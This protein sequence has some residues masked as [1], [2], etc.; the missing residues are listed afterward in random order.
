LSPRPPLLDV[1]P[2]NEFEICRLDESKSTGFGFF[3]SWKMCELLDI[4]LSALQ[5]LEL[6]DVIVK[7]GLKQTPGNE[8]SRME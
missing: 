3:L 2:E 8:T 6:K 5:K 7:M 4:A 1:R